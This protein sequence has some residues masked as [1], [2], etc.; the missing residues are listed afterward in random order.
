MAERVGVSPSRLLLFAASCREPL[1]P[2]IGDACATEGFAPIGEGLPLLA[3]CAAAMS[4]E[5]ALDVKILDRCPALNRYSGLGGGRVGIAGSPQQGIQRA[6]WAC[7]AS[8]PDRR[9][10]LALR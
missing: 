2:S 7:P 8:G 4:L 1:S 10:S 5:M 3:A 9:S 6:L